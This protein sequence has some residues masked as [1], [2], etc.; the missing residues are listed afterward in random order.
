MRLVD[1]AQ[2]SQL[3][4]GVG[5]RNLA[6]F[7]RQQ[8]APDLLDHR[9]GPGRQRRDLLHVDGLAGRHLDIVGNQVSNDRRDGNGHFV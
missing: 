8:H 4:G 7:R 2:G 1:A 6:G 3:G 5:G 9:P